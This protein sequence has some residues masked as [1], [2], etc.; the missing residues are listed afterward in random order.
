MP[1]ERAARD[2]FLAAAE[3]I[4][5][6][7]A[8]T[9][10]IDELIPCG[11]LS[12]EEAGQIRAISE[13]L[14]RCVIDEAPL[15]RTLRD[16][17]AALLTIFNE[18]SVAA[19]IW[20]ND[21]IVRAREVLEHTKPGSDQQNLDTALGYI[22]VLLDIIRGLDEGEECT[23]L[24]LRHNEYIVE[25]MDFVRTHSKPESADDQPYTVVGFVSVDELIAHLRKREEQPDAESD[26]GDEDEDWIVP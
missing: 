11:W 26:Y 14:L 5:K 10:E 2:D 6:L 17:I 16:S 15:V 19:V 1:T 12:Q 13:F 22:N 7:M 8:I 20:E 4:R 24:V 25:A 3:H 18:D 21:R 9:D 23:Q